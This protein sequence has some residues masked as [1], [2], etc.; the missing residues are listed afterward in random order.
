MAAR[1][2]VE[3]STPMPAPSPSRPA[4]PRPSALRRPVPSPDGPRWLV[5]VSAR[6]LEAL[7]RAASLLHRLDGFV[8]D[9]AQLATLVDAGSAASAAAARD[10]GDAAPTALTV[11]Q[12]EILL[13]MATGLGT[14]EIAARL[15]LSRSTVRNHVAR[16]LRQ[17]GCHSRLSAVARAREQSLI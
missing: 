5:P 2:F 15:F 3:S 4:F 6:Q 8:D 14:D 13:L 10:E 17:L 12:R 9:A 1:S 7:R 16:I 11:R